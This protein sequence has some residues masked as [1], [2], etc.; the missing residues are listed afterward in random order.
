MRFST[1]R[2]VGGFALRM[3]QAVAL[4]AA[5]TV[6]AVNAQEPVVEEIVVTATK[7]ETTMKDTPAAI[8]AVSGDAIRESQAFSLESFTRLDPSIQVNN[9]GV[10]D[11]QIIVRG[12]SSSG[13]PT[14]GLYFD[15][16]VITG[17]G[18][19]GGSDNQPNIQ[20]HDMERVEVLK[21]PQG[22]LFGAGSMSGTVRFITNKPDLSR[23]SFGFS[24]SAASVKDGN[25][26][27]QGEFMANVPL[28]QDKLGARAVV[29]GDSGGGYIDQTSSA[30]Y[31]E[32]VNDHSIWGGRLILASQVTDAL[33]VTATGLYQESEA[34]GSQYF[35]FGQPDYQN[36]SPTLEPFEDE[37]RLFSL[38]ADYTTGFGVFTA[39][40]SY[41][42][43]ELYFSRDS[44]PTARFFGVPFDLA[45][46]QGQEISNWSSE[47]RFASTF[48]GPLQFVAGAFYAELEADSQNAALLVFDDSGVATCRFHNDCVANGFASTDI[49]SALV[50]TNIDQ[51]ALFSEVEY[52]FSE[53]W[54]GTLGVRYYDA[55][56]FE[57]KIETQE[58][59]RP[60][61]AEPR[62]LLAETVSED[63]ISY[64]FALS[65]AATD[66]TTFY[67]RIASGFRPGGV[68]DWRSAAARG[69]SVPAKYDS[70]TLWNYELGVKSYMFDRALYTELSVYRIDW[71]DQQISLQDPNA[72]FAYIGNAGKS[73]VNG[74]ELQ[75]N[76]QP[77]DTLTLSIGATYTDS[78]L[79][80]D[81]P[82]PPIPPPTEQDPNPTQPPYGFEGDRIPYSPKWAFAGS[83]QYEIPF[84]SD[85][86]GY[87]STNFNYRSV[88]Y[89]AFNRS[90]G[91]TNYQELDNYFL[92]GVRFGVRYGAWDTSVFVENV[93]DEVPDLGL[94]VTG[95]GYRVYTA[96]P[97]TAG[98][99]VS[100][101]F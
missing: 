30:G 35:E 54:T 81:M 57:G 67:A 26:L 31:A 28:I 13:K 25:E 61:Q 51:L 100:T 17:L 15:E 88:S 34:D 11:N 16:A 87:A 5:A 37:T 62:V 89:T 8:A 70:D 71:S 32:N 47:V 2:S 53:K 7:R 99:R 68:N 66:D 60:P 45:Y 95:D 79:S 33:K 72:I 92:M 12:I 98:V 3:S 69:V 24:G 52:K 49:N 38:V 90:F 41:M 73:F 4:A 91:A 77:T 43:R 42:D 27:Y 14:V 18:L 82:V 9:R 36:I 21:G 23:S 58:L 10:G 85:V 65:Y 29:W 93:T 86:T 59:A 94:R 80:E 64:N 96:R 46:H 20:L 97:M 55:D 78:R 76:A 56:I 101:R 75:I 44:T 40:T 22:T 74:V 39:T 1:T 19:D 48:D 83:A 84:S 63:E 6:P 50:E